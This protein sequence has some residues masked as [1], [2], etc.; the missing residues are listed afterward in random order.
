MLELAR[1]ALVEGRLV[2]RVAGG[3]GLRRGR[4]Y[5]PDMASAQAQNTITQTPQATGADQGANFRV[6]RAHGL[7]GIG[8]NGNVDAAVRTYNAG[9]VGGPSRPAI[10]FFDLSSVFTWRTLIFLLA[11]GYIVGFHVT[12]PG[13]GRVRL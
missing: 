11:V 2:P 12:L 10:D 3:S 9:G 1:Y 8:T 7:V 13:L 6:P 5:T 4:T